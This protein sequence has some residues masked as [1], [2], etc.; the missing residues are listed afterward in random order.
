LFRPSLR[1]TPVL[2]PTVNVLRTGT[3]LKKPFNSSHLVLPFY[4]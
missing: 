2:T 1:D 3:L 4:S